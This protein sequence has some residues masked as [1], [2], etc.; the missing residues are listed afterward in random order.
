MKSI[1]QKPSFLLL[2]FALFSINLLA[3][4]QVVTLNQ[5]NTASLLSEATEKGL[6]QVY[7][8]ESQAISIPQEPFLAYSIIWEADNIS[9]DVRFSNDNEK[10]GEW[11]AIEADGHAHR[12][13][14]KH[15]SRLYFEE[16]QAQFVQIK[17]TGLATDID[18]NESIEIQLFNPQ[19]STDVDLPNPIATLRSCPCPYPDV[20]TRAEWCPDGSCTE[21]PSPSPTTVTHMIVHHSATA[22]TAS[23]W[24]AVVRSIWDFH[25]FSNGWSDIGYNYL[26]DPL[27]N[28][29]EGRGDAIQGAHF[30]GQNANTLGICMIGDFA[31]SASP[32][33]AAMD[34]LKELT[35]WKSCEGDIDAEGTSVHNSSNL[36]LDHISGHRDGCNTT[37]PGDNL[38]NLLTNFRTDVTDYIDNGCENTQI[39]IEAPTN[40]IGSA[41]VEGSVLL[42]WN[43]QSDN[44]TSF[45]IERSIGNNTTFVNIGTSSA[46]ISNFLNE[47]VN[48]S[49]TYFYRVRAVNTSTQSA[50]SNEIQINTPTYTSVNEY[51]NTNTIKLYPNPVDSNLTYQLDNELRGNLSI[52][53]FDINGS[54]IKQLDIQKQAQDLTQTIDV[55]ELAAGIYIVQMQLNSEVG[56]MPF[57]K[58]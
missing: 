56:S 19:A 40:L 34:A 21:N 26:I 41:N 11:Q 55:A 46:N 43:D 7:Q 5:Y 2:L 44:E 17:K 53:I 29:Y 22:N 4:R 45:Q 8:Y 57:I 51:F 15:V 49:T 13:D 16:D 50:Y 28:V 52:T 47:S 48:E 39:E 1:N 10:W 42:A 3:Q 35:A 36:N 18:E 14:H 25:V 23:D 38:Y 58:N 27:G 32:S 20:Q 24:A 9:L 33:A 31:G 54:L 37:C 30:C 6:V 12:A